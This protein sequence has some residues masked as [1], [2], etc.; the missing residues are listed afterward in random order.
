MHTRK[1]MTHKLEIARFKD[2]SRVL[3]PGV[4]SV[5]WFYG[6]RKHCPG[7]IAHRMNTS[8]EFQ[9]QTAQELAEQI[10]AIEDT[11]GVTFSGGEPF[12]QEHESLLILL[13]KV[14]KAGKNIICFT[15][16]HIEDIESFPLGKRLLAEIDL[17]VDGEYREDE[18]HGTTLR[19]SDNQRM[20]FLTDCFATEK[21]SLETGHERGIEFDLGLNH[22]LDITGIPEVGF[23]DSIEKK[24]SENGFEINW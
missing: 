1:E 14:R 17:L 2:K 18:N 8:G 11:E 22:T 13:K 7:C 21:E 9:L 10:I 19:G 3:G 23:L 15:G 20:F 6:C 24:M 12:D 5:V 16:Y 4:R